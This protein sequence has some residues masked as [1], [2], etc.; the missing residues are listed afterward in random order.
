MSSEGPAAEVERL[1]VRVAELEAE[2]ASKPQIDRASLFRM[3]DNAPWGVMAINTG[4]RIDY[5]NPSMQPWLLV[6]APAIGAR[7]AEAMAASLRDVLDAPVAAALEGREY[8]AQL[9]LRAA[10]GEA[11]EVRL[12]VAPR[13]GDGQPVTGVIVTLYDVTETQALDRSVRENEA[14]LTHINAVTPTANYI[15]DY[16]A[17]G[18]PWAGGMIEG[19]FGYSAEQ[20]RRADRAFHRALIHPDDLASVIDRVAALSRRPDGSVL[21]LELRVRHPDGSFRWILDRGAVFEREP[22]GR[23]AKTLNVA[24]DIDERKRAED[25]RILLINELNH[26][27]KNTLATVQSIARQTLRADRPPAQ[28]FEIF[29]ARLVALSAAHDVLTRENWEGARLGEIVAGALAPFA[30]EAEQRLRFEGPEVRLSARAA[31]GLAMALH[32]LATNAVKYGSL[33]NDSGRV[34]LTWRITPGSDRP[35]LEL[36]WREQGGPPVVAPRRGGFGVRLLTQGLRSELDGTAE[37]DFAPGGLVCR[38]AAP[39]EPADTG[40]TTTAAAGT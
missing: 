29:T 27:V 18:V 6:P 2:L 30:A 15:F 34:D 5:A 21:E 31:L 4:R 16:I 13:G 22:A 17:G 14:R 19:V 12:H 33:S 37:L 20:M 24:I 9:S 25:R 10:D 26:R 36:E 40:R 23:V 38:I 11:R 39:V 7:D 35:L 3:V 8:V 1:R 28:T 32:E